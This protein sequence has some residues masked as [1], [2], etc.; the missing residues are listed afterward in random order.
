MISF[1]NVS[2]SYGDKKVLNNFS[3]TIN[4]G[5][6]V[7]FF[8]ESGIGKT[9]IIRLILGL[10]K[11]GDNSVACDNQ[12]YSVV[13]QEDRLLPFKTVE[14]NIT[15]FSNANEIDY[16]LSSLGILDIKNKYPSELS[17]G[18]SRR[19]AIARA[20]SIDADV[21]IFDE[22]FTGLDRNNILSA[23]KLINEI[24]KNKT[25]ILVTHDKEY[26]RLLHCKEIEIKK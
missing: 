17:G 1:T 19:V 11:T 3:L 14:E 21:Y 8:G 5:D 9:T 25:L 10:E 24:T 7:C 4:N 22:P 13:F 16:I 15:F 18:M 20:L 2:F 12:K 26:S 6:R 23:I